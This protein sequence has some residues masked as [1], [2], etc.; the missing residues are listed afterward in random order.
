MDGGNDPYIHSYGL[1]VIQDLIPCK[2]SPVGRRAPDRIPVSVYPL[3]GY[4]PACGRDSECLLVNM[5]RREFLKLTST[6]SAAAAFNAISSRL[7]N[8]LQKDNR[9]PNI[10]ILLFDTMSA[11]HSSLYGYGRPTTPNLEKFA[12]RATVYHSHIS[13]GNFTTPGTASLLTGTYPW[14]HRAINHRGPVA[15]AQADRN[16]FNLLGDSYRRVGYAQNTWANVLLSQFRSEIDVHLPPSAFTEKH[17]VLPLSEILKRDPILSYFSFEEFMALGKQSVNPMP[18]SLTYAITD[19]LYTSTQ[20]ETERTDKY[21][22]GQPTNFYSFYDLSGLLSGA[23][24]TL[25]EL[26]ATSQPF[27]AY[28]HFFPPHEPYTPTI[29]FLDIYEADDIELPFKPRHKMADSHYNVK[30]LRR[31]RKEY[32]EFITNLDFEIGLLLDHLRNS[33]LTDN[34]YVIITSDHGH[35]F[36]RG[37]HAHGTAL[38]YESVIHVPLIISA[39]GQTQRSDVYVPTSSIDVLPTLLHLG[40]QPIPN[41]L[42]GKLLPGLGGIEDPNRSIF[43]MVAKTNSAFLPFTVCTVTITRGSHKLIHY[44]GYPG[45]DG[46]SELYD[47]Q[48]DPDEKK[49]LIDRDPEIG[50]ILK[51][52]LLESLDAANRQIVEHRTE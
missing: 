15:R 44:V 9:N 38:M 20:G 39:P 5:R 43:S 17:R 52:E 28:M 42:P 6:F 31:F 4:F 27:L 7:Q 47:L 33:G 23:A 11:R 14:T 29:D 12:E 26:A 50:R 41:D 10:I 22:N 13:A 45:Y 30:A 46:R 18:G 51:Q 40:G 49:D 25:S 3:G 1:L 34:S 37:E 24:N 48:E 8:P 2:R 16:L 36:E 35:L 32:D 19:L 21:P